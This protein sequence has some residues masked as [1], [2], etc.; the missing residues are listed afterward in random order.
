[1]FLNLF[2]IVSILNNNVT[3]RLRESYFKKN[4]FIIYKEIENYV[5]KLNILNL[6]FK[7]KVWYWVFNIENIILCKVC[8]KPT[9][10][11]KPWIK[12]YRKYCSVKCISKD[13]NI[14]NKKKNNFLKKYGVDH[15]MKL[16]IIKKRVCNTNIEKYG[17]KHV[18]K[19]DKIKENRKE[20][21]L[22]KYGKEY[23]TQTKKYKLNV[24]KTNL[25][26]YGKEY[27]IQNLIIKEKVRNTNLEKYG[28]DHHMK[29]DV[30][31]D[32]FLKINNKKTFEKYKDI[33]MK[34]YDINSYNDH[35]FNLYHKK[36]KNEIIINYS[37]LYNRLDSNIEICLKCN[38]INNPVS[39]KENEVKLFLDELKIQYIENDR[40]VLNGKD[41]DIYLPE[42]K[43]G[44]EFNG[45]YWHS[46]LYKEKDYHLNKTMICKKRNIELLHIFE[47]DWM[48]KQHI[49]KSIILNKLNLIQ[50][51]I[52]ARKCVVKEVKSNIARF[53]LDNN[54]I[55]GFSKSSYKL[56]LYY[57]N[58]LVSLMT[59]GYRHTNSKKEFEL[60][61]F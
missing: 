3:G 25:K 51:K 33:I 8:N 61:R 5:K 30:F 31:K 53:F 21:N 9:K 38:P 60:I 50:N 6:T 36:C 23:Y 59:F 20:T 4:Y 15:H 39:N 16:D 28:V 22:K 32:K 35:I 52:Y 12:G 1:M 17:F 14:I 57:N 42:Y 46:E 40:Y 19:N 13:N 45:L 41:L 47:D 55:Q 7:E 44:I 29:S 24:K 48:F 37:L 43:I 56:G 2:F 49:I 26:K 18:L 10:F 54:H 27:P 58:E 11:D 34:E